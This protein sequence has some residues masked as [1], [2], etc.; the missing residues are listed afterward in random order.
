MNAL[1]EAKTESSVDNGSNPRNSSTDRTSKD[2]YKRDE[3][4]EQIKIPVRRLTVRWMRA[5]FIRTDGIVCVRTRDLASVARYPI[6]EVMAP[7]LETTRIAIVYL[8]EF[9]H[10]IANIDKRISYNRVYES[11]QR[12]IRY[13]APH[14]RTTPKF[15]LDRFTLTPMRGHQKR[16]SK[17]DR[18]T[19]IQTDCAKLL[20]S[21]FRFSM[22][23]HPKSGNPVLSQI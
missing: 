10:A 19:D 8:L 4:M 22:V 6:L 5:H 2:Y 18:Q 9:S 3:K 13:N 16:S 17:T 12:L 11:P 23:V 7:T 21:T 14:N 20:F 15:H 1:S